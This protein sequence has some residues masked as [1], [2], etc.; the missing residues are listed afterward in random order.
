MYLLTEKFFDFKMLVQLQ[1]KHKDLFPNKSVLL[2][3]K[4]DYVA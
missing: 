3:G 2:I 4:E 1:G